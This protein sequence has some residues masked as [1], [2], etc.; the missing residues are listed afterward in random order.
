[1]RELVFF[2]SLLSACAAIGWASNLNGQEKVRTGGSNE[3]RVVLVFSGLPQDAAVTAIPV[4]TGDETSTQ[5][6]VVQATDAATSP[7]IQA[8]V[9]KQ[10]ETPN[11]S[12]QFE[13]YSKQPDDSAAPASQE[14]TARMPLNARHV[15]YDD[16]STVGQTDPRFVRYDDHSTV[17]QF[18]PPSREDVDSG[19]PLDDKGCCD[20]W[21]GFCPMPRRTWGY[22]N[23][24]QR[25]GLVSHRNCDQNGCL[26]K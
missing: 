12:P 11:R 10:N 19:Y 3:V 4:E 7:I 22:C 8:I 5:V 17:G 15:I 24:F 13:W 18:G 14:Q 21:A 20:E 16:H 23:C 25:P 1:M 26:H 6:E 2:W 9:P